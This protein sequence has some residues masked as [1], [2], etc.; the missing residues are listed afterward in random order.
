MSELMVSELL[1]PPPSDRMHLARMLVESITVESEQTVLSEAQKK[2][3]D[4]RLKLAA[5]GKL[6]Y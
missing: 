1:K 2:E 4:R 6:N 5:E 3:L